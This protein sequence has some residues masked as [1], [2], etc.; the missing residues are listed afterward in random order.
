MLPGNMKCTGQF[1]LNG[2]SAQENELENPDGREKIVS[3]TLV[4]KT[5]KIFLLMALGM[6]S[7]SNCMFCQT[8]TQTSAPGNM[9]ISVASSAN[10]SNLV[11]VSASLFTP[12]YISTNSGQT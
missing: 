12:P 5:M 2:V 7:T 3:R 6:L 8:W 4:V 10:G 9:W 11:A 1:E